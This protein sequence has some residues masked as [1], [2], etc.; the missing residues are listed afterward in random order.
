MHFGLISGKTDS[1]RRIFRMVKKNTNTDAK[2]ICFL[3]K[4]IPRFRILSCSKRIR[5]ILQKGKFRFG[6]KGQKGLWQI[7]GS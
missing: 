1:Y 2:V 4:K 6:L 7:Y 5:E 3:K